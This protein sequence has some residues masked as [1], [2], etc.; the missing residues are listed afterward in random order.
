MNR[1]S[2]SQ[3]SLLKEKYR[4]EIPEN[5]RILFGKFYFFSLIYLIFFL[6]IYPFILMKTINIVNLAIILVVLSICYLL[7]IIDV[8]RK[9]KNFNSNLF[10]ILIIFVILAISFSIVK[11]W[12]NFSIFFV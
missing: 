12:L 1:N 6:I 9:K 11:F 5:I 7:I 8:M 3:K 2:R 4:A 10:V